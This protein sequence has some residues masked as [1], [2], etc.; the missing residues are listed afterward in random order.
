V[1][2][3]SRPSFD[4]KMLTAGVEFSTTIGAQLDAA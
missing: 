3:V 1:V 2:W 4:A